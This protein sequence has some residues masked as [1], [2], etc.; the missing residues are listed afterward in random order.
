MPPQRALRQPRLGRSQPARRPGAERPASPGEP[1]APGSSS[2]PR[3]PQHAASRTG[4]RAAPWWPGR[5]GRNPGGHR[6]RSCSDPRRSRTV[7]Q[8]RRRVCS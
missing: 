7:W 6:E 4:T 3:P 1:P 5:H 2:G 8:S